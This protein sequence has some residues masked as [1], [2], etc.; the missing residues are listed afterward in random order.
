MIINPLVPF[1]V[2]N[3]STTSTHASA[4]I[5]N[6]AISTGGRSLADGYD[7]TPW[8]SSEVGFTTKSSPLKP[9]SIR[10]LS[11]FPPGFV[12]LFEA[13]ITTILLGHINSFAII[14]RFFTMSQKYD[15]SLAQYL[16]LF[17]NQVYSITAN[18]FSNFEWYE[19]IIWQ[20]EDLKIWRWSSHLKGMMNAEF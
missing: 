7:F 1:W 20:W 4:G 3:V 8:T 9:L 15:Y 2:A 10:F 14:M 12:T 5:A 6:T 13:P 19:N 16:I 11:N 18:A 17:T